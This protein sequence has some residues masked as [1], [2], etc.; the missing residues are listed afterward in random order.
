MT[1]FWGGLDQEKKGG[2][3]HGCSGMGTLRGDMGPY[4][5]YPVHYKLAPDS[6][7]GDQDSVK[8]AEHVY[9]SVAFHTHVRHTLESSPHE[10]DIGSCFFP[11]F[12]FRFEVVSVLLRWDWTQGNQW[13]A[14]GVYAGDGGP[15]IL[16]AGSSS[17]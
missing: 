3:F 12:L 11:S 1:N 10:I 4:I 7:V 8:E 16:T 9:S 5:P 13:I 6:R 15:R 17:I 14:A 2:F